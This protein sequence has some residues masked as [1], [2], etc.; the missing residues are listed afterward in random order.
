VRER[1]RRI[2]LAFWVN[3]VAMTITSSTPPVGP[4]LRH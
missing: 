1:H 3:S 4:D 2:D